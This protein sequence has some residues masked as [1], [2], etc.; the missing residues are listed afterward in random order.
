M[1][2]FLLLLFLIITWAESQVKSIVFDLNGVLFFNKTSFQ[3]KRLGLLSLAL[4]TMKGLNN[5]FKIK[6][7]LFA[8][9]NEA[10]IAP[11]NQNTVLAR[12]EKGNV[13]PY[14]IDAWLDGTMQ[15]HTIIT[16]FKE[17]LL[18]NK[19]LKIIEKKIFYRLALMIFDPSLFAQAQVVS[20]EGIEAVKTLKKSG[21]KLYVLSNWPQDSFGLI[22]EQ[23]KDLFDQ[24]DGILISGECHINK[25]NP[26][27]YQ[28]L[29]TQFNLSPH[30]TVFI[31]DQQI[32]VIAAQQCGIHGIVCPVKGFLKKRP[33]FLKIIQI[34][35][36]LDE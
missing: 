8:L 25:P 18:N 17:Y 20:H 3:I 2:Q 13:L 19:N 5:P 10:F 24:F 22:K 16:Q 9:L 6:N 33:D 29:L 15:S 35:S 7:R 23:H 27:I 12:D 32:N 34:I 28:K 4:Y 14:V 11:L 1:K 26:R 30:E 31:D 36:V 21:Y